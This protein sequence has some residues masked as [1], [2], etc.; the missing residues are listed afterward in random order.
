M[1]YIYYWDY[2][3]ECGHVCTLEDIKEM[4]TWE[5]IEIKI[6]CIEND[7]MYLEVWQDPD[8]DENN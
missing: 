7:T 4:L 1:R 5:D 2:D 8:Y 3:T 6:Q